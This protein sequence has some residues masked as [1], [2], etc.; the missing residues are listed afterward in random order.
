MTIETFGEVESQDPCLLSLYLRILR[1]ATLYTNALSIAPFPEQVTQHM[2]VTVSWFRDTNDPE[3]WYF[4]KQLVIP[5]YPASDFFDGSSEPLSIDN[6]GHDSGQIIIS[7][8]VNLGSFRMLA[9]QQDSRDSPFYIGDPTINVVESVSSTAVSSSDVIITSVDPIPTS[10]PEAGKNIASN[11]TDLSTV[12][13][14]VHPSGSEINNS[15]MQSR[16]SI[17]ASSTIGMPPESSAPATAKSFK[18]SG[19][20]LG[21]LLAAVT[22]CFC[23]TIWICRHRM[24]FKSSKRRDT[25]AESG[26]KQ[27]TKSN[28]RRISPFNLHNSSASNTMGGDIAHPLNTLA[29]DSNSLCCDGS[30]DER[31]TSS[32]TTSRNTRIPVSRRF[33]GSRSRIHQAGNKVKAFCHRQET[34]ATPH[35]DSSKNYGPVQREISSDSDITQGDSNNRYDRGVESSSQ[36]SVVWAWAQNTHRPL[37]VVRHL[38]SGIR[39]PMVQMLRGRQTEEDI[40]IQAQTGG[41]ELGEGGDEEV[42]DIPPEYTIG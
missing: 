36:Q 15:I 29:N 19:A 5:T 24:L 8:T 2:P 37:T 12:E 22:I 6:A 3:D 23:T 9:F 41:N 14:T 4:E 10:T 31:G 38:D 13:H 39:I 27:S 34:T 42:I 18:M 33:M 26:V 35:Q 20:G 28:W 40:N 25:E 11:T 17:F 32:G 7:F 1:L 16:T 30:D 21:I